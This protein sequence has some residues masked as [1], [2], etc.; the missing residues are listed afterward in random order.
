ML[1]NKEWYKS[2]AVW[3]SAV[4]LIVAIMTSAF[5]ADAQLTQVII[6]IASAL[7]L[8]GRLTATEKLK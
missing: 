1:K 8:Y 2:K 3:G 7:G 6:A 4:A 5:G